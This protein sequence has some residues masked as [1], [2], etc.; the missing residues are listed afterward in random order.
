MAWFLL[1][2]SLFLTVRIYATWIGYYQLLVYG[3]KGSAFDTPRDWNWRPVVTFMM[4]SFNEGQVVCESIESI[5]DSDYPKELIEIIAVDDCSLDDTWEWLQKMRDK[6]PDNLV[7]WK[8]PQNQGK[9]L[10][11][12]DIVHKARGEIVFTVDSDTVIENN[13]IKEIVSCYAD[14]EIAGVCGFVLCKNL[15]DSVWTQMQG[16]FFGVYYFLN[17]VLENQ[18]KTARVLCGPCASFRKEVFIEVTP[19]IKNRE[20]LGAKPIMC[21]EDAYV[22]TR[23]C[24]GDG[25]GKRWKVFNNFDA[26]SWSNNP[27]TTNGYLKQQLRWWRSQSVAYLILV[28]L[29]ANLCRS[30]FFPVM[31]AT[32]SARTTLSVLFILPF[33]FFSGKILSVLAVMLLGS[34]FTGTIMALLYNYFIGRHD[35]VA[36]KIKNPIL[37]GTWTGVWGVTGWFALA[38]LSIFTM[39]DGAW[40]TRQNGLSNDPKKT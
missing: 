3:T 32:I 30:G 2:L 31:I 14:P 12:I 17:K 1:I 25:I 15:N 38:L 19:L 26:H 13:V 33:F 18:F 22:T 7:V 40:V 35:K 5:M 27:S 20:F 28:N 11:L 29:W 23:I 24:M 10:S 9:P 8:N 37:A 6:Y 21:G 36:G 39:D 34:I 16:L 4:P